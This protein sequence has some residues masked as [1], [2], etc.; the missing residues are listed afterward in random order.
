V[1][2]QAHLEVRRYLLPLQ[3]T[4]KPTHGSNNGAYNSTPRIS[5]RVGTDKTGVVISCTQ[6]KVCRVRLATG[7]CTARK[8]PVHLRTVFPPTFCSSNEF[9]SSRRLSRHANIFDN[10]FEYTDR[11]HGAFA[12]PHHHIWQP[13]FVL[14][15]AH[16]RQGPGGTSAWSIS[17]RPLDPA[18]RPLA[19]NS[20]GILTVSLINGVPPP[21]LAIQLQPHQ[22]SDLR[23]SANFHGSLAPSRLWSKW[24]KSS[25]SHCP[26][27]GVAMGSIANG[28]TSIRS[29]R[30]VLGNASSS[31]IRS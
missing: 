13:P 3:Q 5:R 24:Q 29:A 12:Q 19:S 17:I 16:R 27:I 22:R 26:R 20:N 11:T 10:Q 30:H 25:Q 15:P 7:V 31:A 6:P 4:R 2:G 9:L 14:P 1:L 8:L 21:A 23:Q 28:K 18:I